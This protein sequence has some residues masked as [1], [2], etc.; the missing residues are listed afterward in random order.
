MNGPPTQFTCGRCNRRGHHALTRWHQLFVCPSCLDDLDT[1]MSPVTRTI[2]LDK[3]LCDRLLP[4]AS[5]RGM[6]VAVLATRMLDI[7]SRETV[8]IDNLLDEE[9]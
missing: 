5:Q 2:A 6:P 3:A 8:L 7:L 4:I 1:P 9:E